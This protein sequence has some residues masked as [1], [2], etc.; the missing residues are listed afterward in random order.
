MRDIFAFNGLIE[1]LNDFIVVHAKAN[2][3][4]QKLKNGQMF[5]EFNKINL[6][7]FTSNLLVYTLLDFYKSSKTLILSAWTTGNTSR[8]AMRF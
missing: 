4:V 5:V 3:L 1:K 8:L 7:Q 6:H 2:L